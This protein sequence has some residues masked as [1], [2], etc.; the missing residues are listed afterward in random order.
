MERAPQ[1][2]PSI[3]AYAL[4]PLRIFFG[5]TFLYAGIDKL[6]LDRGFFDP[7]SPTSIQAQFVIFERVS[8]LAPLVHLAEPFAPILGVLIA[9]GEI[10]AGLGVLTGL[11]YRLAALGGALLSALFF[12]TASWATHPYYFGNDLPYAFGWLTLALAGH[13]NLYVLRIARVESEDEPLVIAG[14]RMP[15]G[16]SRRL[17]LQLG[18]LTV[19]T[20]G[21]GSL[22]GGLRWLTPVASSGDGTGGPVGSPSPAPSTT[23]QPSFNGVA[24]ANVADFDAHPSRRF[25]VPIGAPSP[26][27]AGD[28][29]IVIKMDDGSFVAYD[30]LCTHEGCRV[31]WDSLSGVIACPCHGAEFDAADHGTVLAGPTNI[32]LPELPL[33]VDAQAGTVVLRYS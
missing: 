31:G 5:A 6:I 20:L 23:P 7:A 11:G 33:A 29:A 2:R 22:L 27:P 30:A 8:P 4:L 32:P 13:A 3:A 24:I 10:G 21:V 25:T 15:A 16:V 19:L 9:L 14:R 18:G 17:V 1:E 28:P 26:L 12:L